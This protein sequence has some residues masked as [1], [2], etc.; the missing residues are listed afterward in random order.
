MK[1]LASRSV[2]VVLASLACVIS[3]APQSDFDFNA[4]AQDLV[5]VQARPAPVSVDRQGAAAANVPV[6]VP[7][8][9]GRK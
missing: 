3:G 5:V 4:L 1:F 6:V 9:D 7:A 8:P 2:F